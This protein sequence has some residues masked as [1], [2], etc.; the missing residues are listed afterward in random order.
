MRRRF[1]RAFSFLRKTPTPQEN[2][3][4]KHAMP[5][6][7]RIQA[8][9]SKEDFEDDLAKVKAARTDQIVMIME[10][11]PDWKWNGEDLDQLK[12]KIEEETV[13]TQECETEANRRLKILQDQ[14]K[15]KS[16]LIVNDNKKTYSE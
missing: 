13:E 6:M 16:G 1:S 15:T 14:L 2:Q 10:L 12:S 9:K 7:E 4:P 8:T 5:C 3:T 11:I